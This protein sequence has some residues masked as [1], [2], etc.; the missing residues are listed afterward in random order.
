V[1]AF[2]LATSTQW[3]A[4]NTGLDVFTSG[5]VS[6]IILNGTTLLAPAGANGFVYRL[7]QGGAD[8]EEIAVRP[9]LL[10]GF[11][12]TDINSDGT[13]ILVANGSSV[14]HSVDDGQSWSLAG[15]G[16][17]NG[18]DIFLAHG[19][20]TFYAV[21]D[22][23]NNTHQFYSSSD[24]GESWQPME[25][26]SNSVVFKIE[27]AGDRLFAARQDGLWWTQIPGTPV[28]PTTWGQIK[29]RFG[30]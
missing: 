5:S 25:A 15:S 16:L 27:V 6:S 11:L 9:P 10:A 17:I 22:F 3:T 14:Y 8:W 12:A 23:L 30:R 24:A 26:V 19:G 20:S 28:H 13:N 29:A 2:D 7:P 1:F 18:S 4:F 21:V